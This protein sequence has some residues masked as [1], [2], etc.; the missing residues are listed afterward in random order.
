MTLPG[1]SIGGNDGIDGALN[2]G[3]TYRA[4][5]LVWVAPNAGSA[6]LALHADGAA[7]TKCVAARLRPG[8]TS[9][10]MC[11]VRAD[12]HAN[13]SVSIEVVVQTSDLGT[14]AR[15]FTHALIR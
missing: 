15:T 9:A 6:T 10:V 12:P 3:H 4:D 1:S 5:V 14:F 13:A 2:R 11:L 7:L 8:K